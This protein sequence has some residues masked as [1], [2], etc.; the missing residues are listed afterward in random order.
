MR[1]RIESDLPP[2]ITFRVHPAECAVC[3]FRNNVPRYN[4]KATGLKAGRHLKGMLLAGRKKPVDFCGI[5]G[6]VLDGAE[7]DRKKTCPVEVKGTATT[8]KVRDRRERREKW[9]SIFESVDA[10]RKMKT[11]LAKRFGDALRM[12]RT[13]AR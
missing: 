2:P 4:E 1:T 9:R 8:A 6:C 5:C 12:E 3:V 7:K 13:P 10:P 11:L